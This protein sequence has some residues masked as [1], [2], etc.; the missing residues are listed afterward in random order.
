MFE[1]LLR[2]IM[3]AGITLIVAY[4]LFLIGFLVYQGVLTFGLVPVIGATLGFSLLTI[5]VYAAMW[6]DR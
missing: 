4:L 3:S 6:W 2:I 5:P 1:L